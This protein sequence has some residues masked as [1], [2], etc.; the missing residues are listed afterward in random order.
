MDYSNQEEIKKQ[1]GKRVKERRLFL[2]LTQDELASKLGY[3]SRATINKIELGKNDLR[4]SKILNMAKILQTTPNYLLGLPE[5]QEE[6]L[7]IAIKKLI[8]GQ[9]DISKL[10]DDAMVEFRKLIQFETD[11]I[12][13]IYLYRKLNERQRENAKAY[14]MGII[15]NSRIE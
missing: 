7:M 5:N 3:K 1:L 9:C 14:I 4:R 12:E 10:D 13:W 8:D 11:E 6:E 15:E 2:N